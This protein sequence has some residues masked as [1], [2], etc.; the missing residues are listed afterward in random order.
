MECVVISAMPLYLHANIPYF[1]EALPAA[2]VPFATF[3]A[4]VLRI[5][6]IRRASTR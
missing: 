4:V 6:W 1:S 5:V 3:S 2:Q